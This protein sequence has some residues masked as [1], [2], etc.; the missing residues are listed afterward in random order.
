MKHQFVFLVTWKNGN[1]EEKVAEGQTE[2]SAFLNLKRSIQFKEVYKIKALGKKGEGELIIYDS[3]L[4]NRQKIFFG[5]W[6]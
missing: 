4:S 2:R 1:K 5:T 6:N 3:K